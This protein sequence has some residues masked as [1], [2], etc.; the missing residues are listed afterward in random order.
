LSLAG[1]EEFG[2]RLLWEEL[3]RRLE[4]DEDDRRVG[5]VE[6]ISGFGMVLDGFLRAMADLPGGYVSGVV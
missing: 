4:T 2:V 1:R 3:E 6:K 5:I